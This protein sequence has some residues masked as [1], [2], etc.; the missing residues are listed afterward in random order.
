MKIL[1]VHNKYQLSG[2][3]DVVV[4]SERKLLE[5]KGHEVF[6][7]IKDNDEINHFSSNTFLALNPI[8]FISSG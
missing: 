5:S 4:E 7:F 2:G 8:F 6:S 1:Q 3:E